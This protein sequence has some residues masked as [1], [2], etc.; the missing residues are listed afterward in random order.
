MTQIFPMVVDLSHWDPADDYEAVKAE[1]IV[2]VIYKATEGQSYTD[3]TYVAQ[4]QAAKACGLRWGS[5]HFADA[6]SVRGQIDNYLRF[7]SPDPDELF[8]LDWED[9]PTGNGMMPLGDVKTW[10][11]EVE[12][13]LGRE[14]QCV[15]YSGNT[16]KEQLGSSVDEFLGSRR[17]WHAQY[18]STPSWQKSWDHYWIW[19]F[20]DGE[21]GPSPHAIDGVGP[22]DV[23]SYDLG[24]AAQ[25]IA[26][27][28]TG[29]ADR[30]PKPGPAPDQPVVNVLIN[31]PP[32]V[33]VKTRIFQFGTPAL[34][35]RQKEAG[36][37]P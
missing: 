23:N 15:L 36:G 34:R 17:L 18:G 2:G 32:G 5:Y 25:L 1:G 28:A 29:S 19:Q 3:P 26:E 4:Q 9:N 7:A 27:W 10:I 33:V 20:T 22:C 35:D 13:S 24:P 12:R 37:T 8:C 30:P 6:S 16:A 14:G 11:T 21:Y 31:A